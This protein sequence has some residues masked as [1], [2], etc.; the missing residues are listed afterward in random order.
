MPELSTTWIDPQSGQKLERRLIGTCSYGRLHTQPNYKTS[1]I[2]LLWSGS[3]LSPGLNDD[4]KRYI[5]RCWSDFAIAINRRLPGPHP[6]KLKNAPG[7]FWL[8]RLPP[9]RYIITPRPN[10]GYGSALFE[11][12]RPKMV[13]LAP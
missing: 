6:V 7:V 11:V 3:N 13:R 5:A 1:G 10:F 2:D 12:H 9:K 8:A 4:L